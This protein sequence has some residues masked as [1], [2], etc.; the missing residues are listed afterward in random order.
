MHGSPWYALRVRPKH[1]RAVATTLERQGFEEYVPLHRVR[2]RWSDRVKE[3]D[4][5]LFP[6][7][8]FCKFDV[9]HRLPI[10][11]VPGVMSIVG[12]G[13]SPLAVSDDEIVAVQNV[14][15]S[16]L[17]YEPSG[18]I[19]TGQLARVERGPLRGLVG[20]VVETKKNCRLVISVNLLQRGDSRVLT[21]AEFTHPSDNSE[22]VN[23]GA[24]YAFHDYLFLRGG[25]KFNY[26]TEGMTAGLG[27]KF[28]LTLSK[29]SVARLD[30]AYQDLKLLTAAH[31]VSVNVS[32]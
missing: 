1:E 29:A 17:T 23:W 25:Y 15:K 28:P 21:V 24:E 30:Y 19:T 5:P 32:F 4:L 3:I 9:L 10:L 12:L 14:V 20:I 7:Y 13:R 6:G 27:V 2:R 16:G 31:R 11:M 18:F 8:I 22:K 26:D